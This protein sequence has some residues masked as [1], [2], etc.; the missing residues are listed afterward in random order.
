VLAPEAPGREIG[1]RCNCPV[2]KVG[3]DEARRMEIL[4]TESRDNDTDDSNVSPTE[5]RHFVM[6]SLC[7]I[8]LS[9]QHGLRVSTLTNTKSED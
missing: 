9:F 5:A 4:L 2:Q 7:E 6:K 1:F 8:G 3:L